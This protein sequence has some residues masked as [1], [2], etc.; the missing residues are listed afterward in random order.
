METFTLANNSSQLSLRIDLN[1]YEI[2]KTRLIRVDL[3]RRY[4]LRDI[5]RYYFRKYL[6]YF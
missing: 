1:S 3:A 4:S 5:L 2:F 6:R